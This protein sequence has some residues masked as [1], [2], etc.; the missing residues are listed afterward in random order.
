MP[1]ERKWYAATIFA[2]HPFM[3]QA[4]TMQLHRAILRRTFHFVCGLLC[5]VVPLTSAFAQPDFCI[6][7][8]REAAFNRYMEQLEL[9]N[10][11]QALSAL[12]Q[13]N[14]TC[15]DTN[16]FAMQM[17]DL[18]RAKGD[19]TSMVIHLR[20]AIKG[21]RTLKDLDAPDSPFRP[22]IAQLACTTQLEL[23]RTQQA[24]L[25]AS[26]DVQEELE[27]LGEMDQ[28]VRE[29]NRE[30]FLVYD[31]LNYARLVQLT[32][33]TGRFIPSSGSLLVLVHVLDNAEKLAY[34]EPLLDHALI[35][36]DI[37]SGSYATILDRAYVLSGRP[38]R[39][40]TDKIYDPKGGAPPLNRFNVARATIGLAPLP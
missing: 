11:D 7:A 2:Y 21:G 30:A 32:R 17:A 27:L 29:H 38:Q 13:A 40:G 25:H 4:S 10:L 20:E 12:R 8:E 39:Y 22:A 33:S 14:S 15:R 34:W 18:Y 37:D 1:T 24:T 5:T 3:D 19:T 35:D 26:T 6:V 28:W 36:G 31:S 9:G 23:Y 16:A